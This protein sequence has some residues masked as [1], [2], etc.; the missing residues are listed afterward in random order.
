VGT[1]TAEVTVTQA[2]CLKV[3]AAITGVDD[4]VVHPE[5]LFAHKEFEQKQKELNRVRYEAVEKIDRGLHPRIRE[6]FSRS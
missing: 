5:R 1:D 3:P 6:V 2:K 4:I